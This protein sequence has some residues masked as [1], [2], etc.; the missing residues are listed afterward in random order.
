VWLYGDL[1]TLEFARAPLSQY[2]V[3]YAANHIQLRTVTPLRQFD[4][5]Y[6]S[7]QL[8]L[9]DL[10]PHEWQLALPLPPY[11]PRRKR[12]ILAVQGRLAM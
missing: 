4:T 5:L 10:A 3:T 2:L 11:A 6:R 7:P 9:W 1:L 8:A 12:S